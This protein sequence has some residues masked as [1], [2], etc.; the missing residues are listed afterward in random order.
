MFVNTDGML[1]STSASRRQ[2]RAIVKPAGLT[3][4]MVSFKDHKDCTAVEKRMEE[5]GIEYLT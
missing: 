4:I 2:S 1:V 3:N 5:D